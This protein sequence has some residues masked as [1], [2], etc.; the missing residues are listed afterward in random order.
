MKKSIVFFTLFLCIF[1]LYAAEPALIKAFNKELAKFYKCKEIQIEK[2]E[3]LSGKGDLYYSVFNDHKKTGIAVL[4]SAEGRFDR[5]D[6][7]VVFNL[8]MKIEHVN[9]LKYS[10]QYGAEITSKRW[11]KQFYKKQKDDFRYGEDIQVIS[12]ATLSAQSLTQ[13]INR[14]KQNLDHQ[15]NDSID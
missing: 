3:E 12:G 2:I 15:F 10:S 6:F 1:K 5:F 13:K 4:T 8:E 9:I 7:M 11:L 14:I